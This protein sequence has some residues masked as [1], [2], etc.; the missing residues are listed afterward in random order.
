MAGLST[1]SRSVGAVLGE[2]PKW[3]TNAHVVDVTTGEI[4]RHRSVELAG[5]RIAGIHA[6]LPVGASDVVDLGGRYLL[7]GIISCHTHLSVVFPFSDTDPAEDPAVTAFRA[8]VRATDALRA[9]ITSIRCVHEQNR[10]D[11]HLRAARARGWILAPRIWGAGR[12]ITTPDGHGSGSACAVA[13]GEDE[14]YRAGIDEL[15]AGADH[16]KIFITGGLAAEGEDPS[17]SEMSDG[18]LDGVVRAASE[19]DTYVVAHSGA[20]TA[21]RQALARGVR[22]F[23]HAY[24]LDA[25]TAA[26]LARRDI[27]VTPTLVVSRCEPWMRANGFA[28]ATIDNAA[29]V[30]GSHLASIR[31]AVAAGVRILGGTDLPP[32]DMVGELAAGVLELVLLQEAGLSTLGALQAATV[33]PALLLGMADR[34]GQ[35]RPGFLADLIAVD[36]DPLA[37]LRALGSVGLVLQGGAVVA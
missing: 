31:R 8:A 34:L 20:S 7:P 13:S 2:R 21:I 3:L 17:R 1:P 11:L 5:D 23:E 6:G 10:V 35:V 37:D 18:E 28:Q 19:H 29:R 27:F 24:E 25:D 12:A 22:C 14:F 36:D 4:H 16:L 15:D 26:L 32:G 9:G 30:A 33:N